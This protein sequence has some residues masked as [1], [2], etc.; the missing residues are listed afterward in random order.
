MPFTDLTSHL[1]FTIPPAIILSV[2]LSPLVTRLDVY[3]ICFLITVSKLHCRC[4]PFVL[5][6]LK[7]AVLYTTPW[8]AYLI[9]NNI[10][11][12]PP[13]AILGPT[14]FRIPLEEL[15]FFVI[16]TYITSLLYIL[17]NK[18][19][20]F[21]VYLRNGLIQDDPNAKR[22]NFR[23]IMG[24]IFFASMSSVPFYG[25]VGNNREGTYMRMICV[26]AGP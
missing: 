20:L 25:S 8:D 19:T 11:T 17:L 12:Y 4:T 7:V 1:L 13:N 14:M 5:N 9:H 10:W 16:Q 2:I 26:W 24:Q 18:P 6:S 22:S 21:P 3:K 23:K 15:F